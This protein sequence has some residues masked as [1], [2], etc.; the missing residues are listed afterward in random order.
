MIHYESKEIVMYVESIGQS[1][2]ITSPFCA[3]FFFLGFGGGAALP[4]A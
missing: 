1:V 3:L 2:S 4:S